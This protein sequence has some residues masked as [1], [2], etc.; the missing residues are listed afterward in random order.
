MLNIGWFIWTELTK[1][2]ELLGRM[3]IMG[4]TRLRC[5]ICGAAECRPAIR[6][7]ASRRYQEIFCHGWN[8]DWREKRG[9]KGDGIKEMKGPPM[10]LLHAVYQYQEPIP[11]RIAPAAVHLDFNGIRFNAIHGGG[12]NLSEHDSE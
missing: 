4:V 9:G 1:L 7:A 11:L 8:T 12:A 10:L 6:Q 5:G 3:G 2:T